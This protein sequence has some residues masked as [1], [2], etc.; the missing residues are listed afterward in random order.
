MST[1]ATD[2]AIERNAELNKTL[3]ALLNESLQQLTKVGVAIGQMTLEPFFRTLMTEFNKMTSGK[4]LFAG[5]CPWCSWSHRRWPLNMVGLKD[6]K[7]TGEEMGDKI[8]KGML[9][10]IGRF[11]QGPGV[12]LFTAVL[13]RLTLTFTKFLAQSGKDFL[14]LNSQSKNQ[15]QTSRTNC[16]STIK[17]TRLY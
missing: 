15:L 10:G 17:R 16:W 11:I 2:E 6:S 9:E 1:E 13:Y 14:N 4:G 7:H 3:K 5:L 12:M 8:G